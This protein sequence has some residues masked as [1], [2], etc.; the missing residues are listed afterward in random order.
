MKEIGSCEMI[1]VFVDN[2]VDKDWINISKSGKIIK[3]RPELI[4]GVVG[5][6]EQAKEEVENGRT[7]NR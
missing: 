2:F 7:K 3:I 4:D 1:R 6:L 5:L